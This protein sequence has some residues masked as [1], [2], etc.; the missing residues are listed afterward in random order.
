V[1]FGQKLLLEGLAAELAATV[2][3]LLAHELM[4]DT[5]RFVIKE[6]SAVLAAVLRVHIALLLVALLQ[7]LGLE[8]A[9]AVLAAKVRVVVAERRM[10]LPFKRTPELFTTVRALKRRLLSGWTSGRG[11][12]LPTAHVRSRSV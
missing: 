10:S 1:R 4:M 3:V 6:A 5:K 7:A 2:R 12:M 11:R 8:A 9:A